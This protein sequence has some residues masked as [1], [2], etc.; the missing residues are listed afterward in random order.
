VDNLLVN[1]VKYSPPGGEV[2]VEVRCAERAGQSW[3]RLAV[4]DHGIGSPPAG[5]PHVFEPFPRGANIVEGHSGT[6]SVDSHEGQGSTFTVWLP[7]AP[8]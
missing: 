6:I 4:R 1:A 3:A 2:T 7:T 8:P 5:L